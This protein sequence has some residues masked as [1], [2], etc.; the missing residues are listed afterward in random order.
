[1]TDHRDPILTR[2]RSRLLDLDPEQFNALD[3]I[4][5]ALVLACLVIADQSQQFTRDILQRSS[6]NM[7]GKV[8]V[9]LFSLLRRQAEQWAKVNVHRAVRQIDRDQV[10]AWINQITKI[11]A[12]ECNILGIRHIS[13]DWRL[14]KV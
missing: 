6:S 9:M 2:L 1:M 13:H 4:L 12:T 14:A 3:D 7:H 10:L 11:T 5:E 8:S